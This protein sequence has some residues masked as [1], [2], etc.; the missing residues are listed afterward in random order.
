MATRLYA[1]SHTRACSKAQTAICD[2]IIK[3]INNY[4]KH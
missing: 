1:E 2:L 4:Y 3:K